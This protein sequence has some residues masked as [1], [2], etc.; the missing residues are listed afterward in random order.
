MGSTAFGHPVAPL[1]LVHGLH[2]IWTS[3]PA[4]KICQAITDEA[5]AQRVALGS[6]EIFGARCPIHLSIQV[7][8]VFRACRRRPCI[9]IFD[10]IDCRKACGVPKRRHRYRDIG[11]QRWYQYAHRCRR[12]TQ[13]PAISWVNIPP[14]ESGIRHP[15]NGY[16]GIVFLM[17]IVT[18]STQ[19][20]E[21][22]A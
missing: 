6:G 16:I 15:T 18:L 4:Q 12:S 2:G 22:Y 1:A 5:K 17:R 20:D 14:D 21:E 19:H 10:L 13:L 7:C 11:R 9:Y 3:C 8:E